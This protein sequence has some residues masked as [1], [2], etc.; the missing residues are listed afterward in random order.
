[1]MVSGWKMCNSN[2]GKGGMESSVVLFKPRIH[3]FACT[4]PLSPT[5]WFVMTGWRAS[6]SLQPFVQL[7]PFDQTRLNCGSYVWILVPCCVQAPV[8]T[9]VSNTFGLMF[10]VCVHASVT[11]PCVSN[12]FG[13]WISVCAHASVSSFVQPRL[14]MVAC[15]FTLPP[16]PK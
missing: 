12:A 16:A 2:K 13:L 4:H 3:L 6:I 11:Q 14:I 1:M 9:R 5:R 8:S 15:L 10:L 7:Q